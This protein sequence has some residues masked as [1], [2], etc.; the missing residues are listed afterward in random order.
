MISERSQIAAGFKT[1]GGF[2]ASKIINEK[3]LYI[4]NH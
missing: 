1:E 4:I 3:L 2:E